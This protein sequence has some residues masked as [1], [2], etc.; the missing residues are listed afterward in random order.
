MIQA[1][2][3]EVEVEVVFRADPL[4]IHCPDAGKDH[5][6]SSQFED[7]TIWIPVPGKR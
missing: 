1:G 4:V 5:C 7:Q 3:A 6:T 2:V